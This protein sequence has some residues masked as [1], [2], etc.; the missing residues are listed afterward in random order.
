M[1]FFRQGGFFLEDPPQGYRRH[2]RLMA[3]DPAHGHAVVPAGR[4][5]H[6]TQRLYLRHERVGNFRNQ[7]LL[8]DQ[9]GG[10][11]L[12]EAGNLGESHDFP[13]RYVSKMH[14]SPIDQEVVGTKGIEIDVGNHDELVVVRGKGRQNLGGL[15]SIARVS[16]RYSRA[17][18]AG[19]PRKC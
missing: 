8:Y 7:I 17:T 13:V 6:A 10:H 14:L 18:R 2:G 15:D 16:S 11:P 9:S 3:F 19:V 5:H 12:D 4:P 1:E